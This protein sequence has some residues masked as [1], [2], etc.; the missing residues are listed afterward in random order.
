MSSRPSLQLE[1]LPAQSLLI[2]AGASALLG[3]LAMSAGYAC[4]A[5]VADVCQPG[6]PLLQSVAITGSLL[7]LIAFAAALAKRRGGDGQGGYRT[8]VVLACLGFVLVALHSTGSVWRPPAFLLLSLAALGILGVWAR[9]SGARK[10]A[11]V[12]GSRPGAF[13]PG[14][15]ERRA[16]LVELMHQKR[17][18]LERLDA[19]ADEGVFSLR[20][21]HWLMHPLLSRDYAVLVQRENELLTDARP[22]P[23]TLRWWRLVHQLLAFGF[24]AGLAIHVLLVTFFAGYVAEGRDV[25]WWH[26][27][28]WNF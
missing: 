27:T 22:A 17:A 13:G 15:A 20:A 8:H 25:Y 7:T 21:P 19:D 10:L 1:E 26:I 12:F 11:N 14:A 9:T 24:V 5:L 2:L 18:V 4:R 28:A 23:A 16:S 6:G 3:V